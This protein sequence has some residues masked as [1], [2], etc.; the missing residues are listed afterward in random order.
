MRL[1][2]AGKRASVNHHLKA[3]VASLFLRDA[4][5]FLWRADLAG[6][7]EF[8]HRS[9]LGKVYVD[10]VMAIECALKASIIYLSPDA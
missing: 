8:Q 6:G 10:Y 3:R 4:N 5:D 7:A 9:W 2:R 1:I